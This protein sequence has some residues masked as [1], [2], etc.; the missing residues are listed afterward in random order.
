MKTRLLPL[1]TN[2]LLGKY[3]KEEF[4][5]MKEIISQTSDKALEHLMHK[6]WL[7]ETMLPLMP[8]AVKKRIKADL[9]LYTTAQSRRSR[10]IQKWRPVAAVAIAFILAG[11]SLLYYNNRNTVYQS[12]FIVKTDKRQKASILLPDNSSVYLNAETALEYDLNN[13]KQRKVYLSGEAY[14]EV[15]KDKDHPFIVDLG[16]LQIEVLGTFFNVQTYK[17]E[18]IIEASL[19]AGSIKLTGKQLTESYYLKPMEQVIYSKKDATLRIIPFDSRQELGW[20]D[21]R[22]VFSSEPLYKII[23]SIE[24]WYDVHIDLQCPEI[25]N[26]LMSG[27]FHDEELENVLEAIKIQYK[28]NYIIKGRQIIISKNQ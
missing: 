26:D 28:V 24:R 14:F 16:E 15:E 21:N 3:S 8:E 27:T 19:I 7:K 6:T 2:Y 25:S 20:M 11:S 18:D 9:H 5:E 23:H 17:N 12:P 1:Y 10:Q 13:K 4:L 22:L